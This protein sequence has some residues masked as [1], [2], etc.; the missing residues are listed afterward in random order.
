MDRELLV[1]VSRSDWKCVNRV[2]CVKSEKCDRKCVSRGGVRR[3]CFNAG[4]QDDFYERTH[5]L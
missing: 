3:V 5:E 4:Q 1:N 2:C